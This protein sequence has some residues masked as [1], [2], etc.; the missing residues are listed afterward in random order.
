MDR[1]DHGASD[2][3][4]GNI[5]L[6]WSL[7]RYLE[8]CYH[9][10]QLVVLILSAGLPIARDSDIES[11]AITALEVFPPGRDRTQHIGS[12]DHNTAEREYKKTTILLRWSSSTGGNWNVAELLDRRFGDH[13]PITI[14]HVHRSLQLGTL[15]PILETSPGSSTNLSHGQTPSYKG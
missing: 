5:S 11:G 15:I 13:I 2:V 6:M 7:V 12:F 4:R 14:R 8:R 3:F 9:S 1:P 10:T